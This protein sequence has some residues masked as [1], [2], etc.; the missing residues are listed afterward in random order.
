MMTFGYQP[1]IIQ[2]LAEANIVPIDKSVESKLWFLE[3]D[4][5]S[6]LEEIIERAQDLIKN[7]DA[8]RADTAANRIADSAGASGPINSIYAKLI[9]QAAEMDSLLR[10]ATTREVK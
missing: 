7:I 9:G 1:K 2:T 4:M 6:N 3:K 8:G 10:F 5:R